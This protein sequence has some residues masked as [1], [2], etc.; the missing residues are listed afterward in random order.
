MGVKTNYTFPI[1]F[2][3]IDGIDVFAKELANN[4]DQ[5]PVN[6]LR[7]NTKYLFDF[8][9]NKLNA[10]TMLVEEHYFSQS[11]FD[12]YKFYH[13]NSYL[14]ISKTCKRIHFFSAS[15]PKF[16]NVVE[17]FLNADVK[18]EFKQ[19][20][21]SYLGYVVIRPLPQA[22]IGATI[23]KHPY[24]NDEHFQACINVTTKENINVFGHSIK[25][26]DSLI[27]QEQGV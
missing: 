19:F 15:V 4:F 1:I 5:F 2:K 8:L 7:Q 11:F 3:N 27:Y 18:N 9:C 25:N 6:K 12:D 17:V 16:D 22:I 20:W 23:L 26:F 14:N 24:T 10:K 13:I 21:I